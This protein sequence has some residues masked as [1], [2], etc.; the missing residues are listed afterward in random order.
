MPGAAAALSALSSGGG[1]TGGAAGP[2]TSGASGTSQT[3]TTAGNINVGGLNLNT[4]FSFDPKN[5]VHLA[6]AAGAV[7]GAVFLIRRLT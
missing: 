5:P 3:E 2:A 7:L 1:L 4:G 6:G